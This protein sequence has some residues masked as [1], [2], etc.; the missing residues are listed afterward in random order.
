M[1]CTARLEGDFYEAN[2]LFVLILGSHVS[3]LV[4][5]HLFTRQVTLRGQTLLVQLQ[6]LSLLLILVMLL[7]TLLL[8]LCTIAFISIC[9]AVPDL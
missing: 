6:G 7:K 9:A 4:E 1:P 5:T 3:G 8:C 2:V